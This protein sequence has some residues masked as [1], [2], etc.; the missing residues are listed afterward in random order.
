MERLTEAILPDNTFLRSIALNGR[1]EIPAAVG[2][3]RQF[4]KFYF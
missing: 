4:F 1:R 2:T 3:I